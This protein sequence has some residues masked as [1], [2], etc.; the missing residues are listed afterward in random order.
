MTDADLSGP[1]PQTPS[2]KAVY[3]VDPTENLPE[4]E[5]LSEGKLGADFCLY[6]T[7]KEFLLLCPKM[8]VYKRQE[9]FDYRNKIAQEG[10]YEEDIDTI[11]KATTWI[12]D[13]GTGV[14]NLWVRRYATFNGRMHFI[15]DHHDGRHRA[16]AALCL[17][18]ERVPVKI[19]I[20][21]NRSE[22]ERDVVV[23]DFDD[24]KRQKSHFGYPEEDDKNYLKY[25]I[26]LKVWKPTYE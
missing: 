6:M 10:L 2:R 16:A 14:L 17:G 7:P 21:D 20:E 11:I 4:T 22:W 3:R 25:I 8:G 23:S 13:T 19:R 18:I 15:V 9:A 24:L 12:M 1:K 26:D 5:W